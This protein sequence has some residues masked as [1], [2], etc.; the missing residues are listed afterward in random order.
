MAEEQWVT[1]EDGSGFRKRIPKDKIQQAME[2]YAQLRGM[3]K[4]PGSLY[5]E[6]EADRIYTLRIVKDEK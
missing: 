5:T 1:V 3:A 6:E 4:K 2:T